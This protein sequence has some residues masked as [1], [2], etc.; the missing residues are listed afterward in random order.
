MGAGGWALGEERASAPHRVG[1]RLERGTRERQD[2][3]W[4]GIGFGLGL[5]LGLGFGFGF[6]FR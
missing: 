2:A 6:G 4:L 5:G 1:S 3:P